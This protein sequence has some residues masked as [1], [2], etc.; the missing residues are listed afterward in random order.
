MLDTSFKSETVITD[1]NLQ[2]DDFITKCNEIGCR[3]MCEE[4]LLDTTKRGKSVKNYK[5]G[6][7]Y[8]VTLDDGTEKYFLT[9]E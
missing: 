6:N 2:V 1:C 4:D 5:V 8:L 9:A 3:Y 7:R